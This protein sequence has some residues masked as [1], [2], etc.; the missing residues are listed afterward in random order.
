ML[1]VFKMQPE[2]FWAELLS[3]NRALGDVLLAINLLGAA[4][5]MACASRAHQDPAGCAFQWILFR[6]NYIATFRAFSSVVLANRSAANDTGLDVA[7][8]EL[9]ATDEAE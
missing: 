4:A 8:A 6:A 2:M 9:F 3:T 1:A 7:F 5:A